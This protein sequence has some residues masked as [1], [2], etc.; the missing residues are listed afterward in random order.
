LSDAEAGPPLSVVVPTH[1]TRDLTLACLASLRAAAGQ[2]TARMEV[3]LVDDGGID[4]TAEE[5]ARLFPEVRLLRL[6]NPA[7]FTHAAN[8]GLAAAAGRVLLLLNSDAEV[9]RTGLQA[10]LARLAGEPGVGVIGGALRYPDGTPQWSG[11]AAPSLAWLFAQASGLPALAARLPLYRRLRPVSAARGSAAVD[12]VTGAAMAVRRAAWE[13]AG[14]LDERFCFYAQDL[15]FC[16]RAKRQGWRI[17]VLPG[18]RVLHHHGATIGR[19]QNLEL[20]W[21]DLLRWAAKAHGR[22]WA[23][24]A[25]WA[26]RCGGN[27]RRLGRACVRPLLSAPRRA[28]F[29]SASADLARALAVLS[30]WRSPGPGEE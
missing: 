9:D 11:G 16:L 7:G 15:D 14:P 24:R 29:Q 13:S 1:N 6:A 28:A 2:E 4:G 22:G 10:M 23:R 18:F 17:E 19:R 8:H 20:L 12:W 25:A 27:L 21:S 3:L 30:A 5:V 26:L